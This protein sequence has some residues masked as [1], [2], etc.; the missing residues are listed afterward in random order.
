MSAE[1]RWVERR[2]KKMPN[3]FGYPEQYQGQPENYIEPP[4]FREEKS[5]E[6]GVIREL[7]PKRVL[8]QVRMNLK[9]WYWDWE[10]EKYVQIDG[11]VPLLNEKGIA[12]YLAVVG[13]V[14]TDL[15]TFSNYSMD[16]IPKLVQYV[17]DKAIP[18]IHIN[19]KEYGVK[20]K[21]DLQIIDIQIFMLTLAAL[22]KAAGAG[23]RGV[24]GRTIQ[25]S[26]MTR[27]G[28]QQQQR[29]QESTFSKLNPFKR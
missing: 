10:A 25:E 28:Q 7:S 27:A 29:N 17:C 18:T 14:V 20:E 3:E 13:S 21:S 22:K 23:D 4:Q 16:E 5:P 11:F 15:V 6:I 8:E 26:I 2:K 12:K 1:V 19:Y 24:I 9:G